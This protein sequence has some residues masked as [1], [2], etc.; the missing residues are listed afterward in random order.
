MLNINGYTEKNI[1][2]YIMRLYMGEINGKNVSNNL[3]WVD[4]AKGIAIFLV[5]MG[6]TYP[7]GGEVCKF[8]FLFHMPLFFLVAGY[9]Y[10]YEKY[11]NNFINLIKSSVKRLL[12]LA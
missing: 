11:K 5:I 12:F 7:P 2:K 8:I 4:I 3:L 9:L 6:H 1:K 10:N